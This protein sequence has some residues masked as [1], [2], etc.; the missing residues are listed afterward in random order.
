MKKYILILT[1]VLTAFTTMLSGC[2]NNEAEDT[3]AE[4]TSEGL[5]TDEE[6]DAEEETSDEEDP[7]DELEK[8]LVGLW[9]NDSQYIE[10]KENNYF[11][12]MGEDRREY[13]G[14]YSLVANG[15]TIALALAENEENIN[16]Y[17]AEF[18]NDMKKLIITD[19]NGDKTEFEYN[20]VKQ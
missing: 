16:T 5:Y 10:F 7:D 17:T 6:T 3:A 2:G 8:S 18:K 11:M 15:K 13:T 4:M 12:A 20:R 19:D 14:T 9:T 1:A